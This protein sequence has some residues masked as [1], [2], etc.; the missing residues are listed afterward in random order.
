MQY[1]Y[2]R[3]GQLE[4]DTYIIT[5][6]YTSVSL[7]YWFH[8]FNIL[9]LHSNFL[10]HWISVIPIWVHYIGITHFVRPTVEGPRDE[11]I[12]VY[13]DHSI[14]ENSIVSSGVG[15]FEGVGE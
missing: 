11:K 13:R 6:N 3:F 8:E 14:M 2:I 1:Q 9:V 15:S 10:V 7:I 5:I 12:I 4:V